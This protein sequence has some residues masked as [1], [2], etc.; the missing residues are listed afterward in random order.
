MGAQKGQRLKVRDADT[1]KVSWRQG[2]KGFVRDNQGGEPTSKIP[3]LSDFV[4]S[5]KMH[6][7][8]ASPKAKDGT[9]DDQSDDE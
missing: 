3:Q 9:S 6:S 1:G 8:H 2:K 4:L 7:A 5:H